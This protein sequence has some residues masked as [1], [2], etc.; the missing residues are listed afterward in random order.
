MGPLADSL[1]KGELKPV[2]YSD[3]KLRDLINLKWCFSLLLSLL[4]WSGLR[5]R[6]AELI[7]L[8]LVVK[9]KM[10][11]TERMK[12]SR[13]DPADFSPGMYTPCTTRYGPDLPG[14]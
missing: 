10:T 5:G 9:K 7:E 6:G 1:F 8:Y 3:T 12:E 2:S 11:A 4:L 14:I 13:F